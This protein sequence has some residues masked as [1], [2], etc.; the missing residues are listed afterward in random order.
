VEEG[1]AGDVV[2]TDAVQKGNDVDFG[3]LAVRRTVRSHLAHVKHTHTPAGDCG[4]CCQ[5]VYIGTI[6]KIGR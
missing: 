4:D 6:N 2:T 1:L 5:A 3:V